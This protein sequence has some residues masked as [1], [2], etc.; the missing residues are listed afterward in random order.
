MTTRE[1]GVSAGPF[2]GLNLRTGLGDDPEAVRHNLAV[3]RG[4]VGADLVWLHQ[5]HGAR[6]VRLQ[7]SDAFPGA[8]V[9]EADAG[10]STIPGL[11]CAVQVADC[12]PV[13][14]SVGGRAVAAAH[15]GWRGLAAGVIE[16]T[17]RALCEAADCEADAIEVWLG[18]CIG[19]RHFEVGAEVLLAFGVDAGRV[20]SAAEGAAGA[21]RP[22]RFVSRGA[23]HPGKWLADLPGLARDRLQAAGV[24]RVTSVDACTVE[25]RSHFF[26]FRRDGLTG[27]MAAAIWLDPRP[28]PGP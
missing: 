25:D 8:Q 10:I 15:A 12:L 17:L 22:A 26:S 16:A 6:V 19:P 20:G 7:A 2:S 11:A 5:V 14:M 23:A 3:L 1:G 27:R 28:G 21:A 18:A 24:Q 9:H 13:L 4:V